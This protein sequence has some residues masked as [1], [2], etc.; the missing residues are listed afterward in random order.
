[1]AHFKQAIAGVRPEELSY[2][3]LQWLDDILHCGKD[4]DDPLRVLE[5]FFKNCQKHLLLLHVKESTLFARKFH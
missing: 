5:L 4:K 3:M 1:M 2:S